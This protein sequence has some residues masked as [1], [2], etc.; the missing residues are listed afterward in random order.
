MTAPPSRPHIG[1]AFLSTP[2]LGTRWPVAVRA[3]VTLAIPALALWVAGQ[4]A[5][6]LLVALG[7]FAMLYGEDRPFRIRWRVVT[8]VGAI[9]IASVAASAYL[10]H[11]LQS[12]VTSADVRESVLVAVMAA[13]TG[14]AVF[15]GTSLR[16]GPPGPM[17]VVLTAGVGWV[18][19][20]HGVAPEIVIGCTA[21]GVA[22]SLVVSMT[23]MLWARH[24]PQTVAIDAAIA[25]VDSYLDAASS[26]TAALAAQASRNIA[27]EQMHNAWTVLHDAAQTDGILADRLWAAHRRL[28]GAAGV[29]ASDFAPP[30]PRPSVV[31]RLPKSA[32]AHT[33]PAYIAGRAIIAALI[34]GGLSILLGLGR[35]DWAII[36]VVLVLQMGPDRVRGSLRGA[37]RMLG[38]SLGLVL[39]VVV[40][41]AEPNHLI[42]I[43]LVIALQFLIE[44]TV[45]SN[46]G[47][48][49]TFITPLAL[50][51]SSPRGAE[52]VWETAGNRLAE[53]MIGVLLAIASLW[54]LWPKGHRATLELAHRRTLTESRDVLDIA[55][56]QSPLTP[57]VSAMRRDLQWTLL[58]ADTAGTN[59]ALDEP[60]WSKK[61]WP[62]HLSVCGA[63]YDVLAACW[64]APTGKPVSAA[65]GQTLTERL[66]SLNAGSQP[67]D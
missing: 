26:N 8:I 52:A 14:A 4:G 43:L 29:A 51:M 17:F 38:T 64:Q 46:Y 65:D 66:S 48:A 30:L 10:A 2:G 9:L 16:A 7:T 22:S 56:T 57:P 63:G 27:G 59:A 54:A 40:A 34:A 53:T 3:A 5:Y 49:A 12:H 31:H 25:A 19:V 67:G 44:L 20:T 62:H 61:Q 60:H 21:L 58:G 41:L 18:I 11:F 1:R 33:L 45:A 6:A 32:H 15:T 47:L 55:I 42:L 28:A 37:Q 50:L 39:F 35:P 24:T 23:P 36:A 13:L